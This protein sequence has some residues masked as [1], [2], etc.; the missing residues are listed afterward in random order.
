MSLYNIRIKGLLSFKLDVRV[1]KLEVVWEITQGIMLFTLRGKK[2]MQEML[3][4][5][6]DAGEQ[7]IISFGADAVKD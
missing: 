4:V 6:S 1:V 7:F 3:T 2:K 5:A